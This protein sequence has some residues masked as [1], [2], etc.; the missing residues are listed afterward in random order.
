MKVAGVCNQQDGIHV[1]IRAFVH[2]CD[3]VK[4]KGSNIPVAALGY[5]P[6][7]A[8]FL[9]SQLAAGAGA[10]RWLVLLVA[11]WGWFFT[12]LGI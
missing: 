10:G 6:Q 7:Q 1:V 9:T 11:V 4:H 2:E 8:I 5:T 3:V 12:I